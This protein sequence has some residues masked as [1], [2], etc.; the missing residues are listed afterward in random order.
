MYS[1]GKS[2][3][4]V[5]DA[6]VLASKATHAVQELFAGFTYL[7]EHAGAGDHNDVDDDGGGESEV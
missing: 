2:H 1:I 3:R 6:P 7:I 4:H 5:H